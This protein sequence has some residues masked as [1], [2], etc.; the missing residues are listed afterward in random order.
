MLLNELM[1]ADEIKPFFQE[2]T[3][4][5]ADNNVHQKIQQIINKYYEPGYD[6]ADEDVESMY[7]DLT[8]V[9]PKE[10]HQKVLSVIHKYV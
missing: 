9:F 4:L 7:R 5:V 1:Y 8:T 6:V 2:L 10:L 3:S